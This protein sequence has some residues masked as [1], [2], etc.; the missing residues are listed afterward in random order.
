[1]D[2]DGRW[3]IVRLFHAYKMDGEIVSSCLRAEFYIIRYD[4]DYYVEKSRC[5]S[6]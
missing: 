2:L 5:G 4:N 6:S 3:R 1:V